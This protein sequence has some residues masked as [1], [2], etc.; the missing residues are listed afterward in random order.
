MYFGG[1]KGS[2]IFFVGLREVGFDFGL[3][4]FKVFGVS[5]FIL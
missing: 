1:S 4:D 5:S 3:F 2:K